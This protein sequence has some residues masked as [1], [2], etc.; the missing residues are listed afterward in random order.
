MPIEKDRYVAAMIVICVMCI[1]NIMQIQMQQFD[2]YFSSV[3]DNGTPYFFDHKK[4]QH[5]DEVATINVAQK[6][7]IRG[8][9]S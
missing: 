3:D 7:D 4:G 2:F 8:R 5:E 1:G 9:R 6:L